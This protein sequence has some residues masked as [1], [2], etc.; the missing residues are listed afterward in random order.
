[1]KGIILLVLTFL[2]STNIQAQIKAKYYLT[3][4]LIKVILEK[5]DVQGV[6]DVD[7]NTIIPTQYYDI[8]R[9]GDG[10]ISVKNISGKIGIFNAKGEQIYP[11]ELDNVKS[12]SNGYA[13]VMKDYKWGL[14]D[15]KGKVVIPFDNFFVD[16]YSDGVLPIWTNDGSKLIDINNKVIIPEG[17]INRIFSFYNGY[18]KASI[19]KDNVVKYG[20]IDKKG[21]W[22]VEPKYDDVVHHS[23]RNAFILI[24]KTTTK[25]KYKTNTTYY[26]GWYN[27][28]TKKLVEPKYKNL[29]LFVDG[30]ALV[31]THD[32]DFT[33][34]IDDNQTVLKKLGFYKSANTVGSN[35]IKML[36]T[37]TKKYKL[38]NN[39]GEQI[40]GVLASSIFSYYDYI[41]TLDN[42]LL[43]LYD[44]KMKLL[45]T[46]NNAK[47]LNVD[48]DRLLV[49][50][51]NTVYIYDGK[52]NKIIETKN[53]N[54]VVNGYIGS[55]GI[56]LKTDKSYQLH[57]LKTNKSKILP[58]SQMSGFNDDGLAVF[59]QG[60]SFGI[61]DVQGNELEKGVNE[62]ITLLNEGTYK[63]QKNYSDVEVSI[64]DKNKNLLFKLP[65]TTQT[66]VFV[67]GLLLTKDNLGFRFLD[68]SG[69][70]IG[71]YAYQ[72]NSYSEELVAFKDNSGKFGF[73]NKKGETVILNLFAGIGDF[74][75]GLAPAAKTTKY[76]F[77]D[78]TGK[79]IIQPEYD[80]VSVFQDGIAIVLNQGK[81]GAIDKTGK[82]IIPIE[83]EQLMYANEGMIYAKQKD[84][85]GFIDLKNKVVAP[86]QYDKA[87]AFSDGYAW[88]QKG[89]AYILIDTKG[90]EVLNDKYIEASGFKNG[91][92]TVKLANGKAGLINTKL[93]TILPLQYESVSQVYQN[94]VITQ[95]DENW[96]KF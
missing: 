51:F 64:Y 26:R 9:V 43:S 58:Y 80:N 89:D 2:F 95:T 3:D 23:S 37:D 25:I 32:D 16:A 21:N 56:Y 92:A 60:T 59:K 88:T 24:N 29:D 65:K 69:K 30:N 18:A 28:N 38:Y 83:Y 35:Y 47:L 67:D 81:Y 15:E 68:K 72:P 4:G 36:D 54:N 8:M 45:K 27:T 70:T 20:V 5:D 49:A 7:G 96:L 48:G 34:I 62:A 17:K 19:L 85:V 10:F 61:I 53:I 87:Y 52:Q 50:D 46:F 84:K 77:I 11:F 33:Y 6:V 90:K 73:N 55:N 86:I 79:Y 66:G 63:L 31:Q 91:Y 14:I 42:N 94:K 57:D 74:K 40:N 41:Y 13:Q 1:M 39:K 71:T 82:Q 44:E 12:Y 76:G 22:I 75:E 93:K 78:K